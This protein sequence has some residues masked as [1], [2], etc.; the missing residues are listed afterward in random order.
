MPSIHIDTPQELKDLETLAL[1]M[2]LGSNIQ[3]LD[4]SHNDLSYEALFI[5]LG[6]EAKSLLSQLNLDSN[7]LTFR[8]FSSL[9]ESLVSVSASTPL[10]FS[11]IQVLSLRHCQLGDDG[12]TELANIFKCSISSQD[13]HL[14]IQ[15]LD[16][17]GNNITDS[18]LSAFSSSLI[19]LLQHGKLNSFLSLVLDQ[20]LITSSGLQSLLPL[21]QTDLFQ[22]SLQTLSLHDNNIDDAGVRFL[23]T[24]IQ[25]G[26][27]SASSCSLRSLSLSKNTFGNEGCRALAECLETS[28]P[29]LHLS[30]SHNHAITADALC[31]LLNAAFASTLRTLDVSGSP[32]S[33]AAV[34]SLRLQPTTAMS[35]LSFDVTSN[36][37]A[38]LF[39]T[40]AVSCFS[41]TTLTIQIRTSSSHHLCAEC[42]ESKPTL[43]HPPRHSPTRTLSQHTRTLNLDVE[44]D[45]EEPK[46]SRALRPSLQ[47]KLDCL[48]TLNRYIHCFDSAC[49]SPINRFEHGN[50]KV[51]DFNW[52]ESMMSPDWMK[53]FCALRETGDED[54]EST[55]SHF[56]SIVDEMIAMV[57][58]PEEVDTLLN[59]TPYMNPKERREQARLTTM[60]K[61][62]VLLPLLVT[63]LTLFAKAEKDVVHPSLPVVLPPS[64]SLGRDQTHFANVMKDREQRMNCVVDSV[65]N[66]LLLF[67]SPTSSPDLHNLVREILVDAEET[68]KTTLHQQLSESMKKYTNQEVESTTDQHSASINSDIQTLTEEIINRSIPQIE[69]QLAFMILDRSPPNS[70]T[71]PHLSLEPNEKEKRRNQFRRLRTSA[72][73]A[74]LRTDRIKEVEHERRVEHM[75]HA[76]VDPIQREVEGIVMQVF[77]TARQ[78]IEKEIR[79]KEEDEMEADLV[80]SD[81]KS[82]AQ[83]NTVGSDL[84][85]FLS[86]IVREKTAQILQNI[87]QS[88]SEREH[89][90]TSR[91]NMA[92]QS[93]RKANQTTLDAQHSL[94]EEKEWIRKE[95][96]RLNSQIDAVVD[97][98]EEESSDG[99]ESEA[100][101]ESQTHPEVVE[102]EQE[103]LFSLSDSE[104][105]ERSTEK[106]HPSKH[107]PDQ[108]D[109]QETLSSLLSPP[110][111]SSPQPDNII[112]DESEKPHSAENKSRSKDRLE[113]RTDKPKKIKQKK[114]EKKSIP[115]KIEELRRFLEERVGK[116][117]KEESDAKESNQETIS[118]IEE[119]LG[120]VKNDSER[121]QQNVSLIEQTHTMEE[122]QRH[123]SQ[124]EKE[125]EQRRERE[126][127]AN[128]K[129]E[130]ERLAQEL[131]SNQTNLSREWS[132]AEAEQ[133][134]FAEKKRVE[135]ELEAERV[136]EKKRKE[137][138]KLKQANGR[139][140]KSDL[141]L[142]AEELKTSTQQTISLLSYQL[143]QDSLA[144]TRTVK[145]LEQKV[146]DLEQTMQT[147]LEATIEATLKV[148]ETSKKGRR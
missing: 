95:V 72:L 49:L 32:L 141:E 42:A 9:S 110:L 80:E 146:L 3:K 78:E 102:N 71:N 119:V 136:M 84:Q 93:L 11:S 126:E 133:K 63:K 76:M 29:L 46:Q 105:E 100:E 135:Y 65:Q 120:E 111:E 15:S 58:S 103:S 38:D 33:E 26:S 94:D 48:A 145:V 19:S 59:F 40:S 54:V 127:D 37:A 128:T 91:L 144:L 13:F 17:S 86:Q 34:S 18:G 6:T 107:Q 35:T 88:H 118:K 50:E 47:C 36:E 21:V 60:L 85:Q 117:Q 31:H 5:L 45:S 87:T 69:E 30:L 53:T 82:Q 106:T 123:R 67:K 124:E 25:S 134:E 28:S 143:M 114:S 116:L 24:T 104:Q 142:K 130:H 97:D 68:L 20:N 79:S 109:Q 55:H 77:E 148:M 99:D 51:T 57:S 16:L 101:E 147:D 125:E 44:D 115:D 131:L 62:K 61:M 56:L 75:R 7:P 108:V 41:L 98:D 112:Q 70:Q 22:S 96:E 1:S 52:D 74:V 81:T 27:A 132:A 8:A 2:S 12:I 129:S 14:S 43:L 10:T 122:E 92:P 66:S 23:A 113:P 121:I 138:M 90:R 137:E 140:V 39:L 64:I 73:S 89:T 139:P 4:V 83:T